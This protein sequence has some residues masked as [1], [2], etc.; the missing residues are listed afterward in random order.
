MVMT[1][2]ESLRFLQDHVH[3]DERGLI[4][5]DEIDLGTAQEVLP[6]V[7]ALHGQTEVITVG[8]AERQL[9]VGMLEML[10]ADK[11]GVGRLPEPR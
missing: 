2:D 11:A 9:P 7:V 6:G 1:M 4:S 8:P 5:T 3:A 10:L